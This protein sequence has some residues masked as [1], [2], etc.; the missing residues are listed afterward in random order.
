MS[1]DAVR[2]EKVKVLR[3][4][5]LAAR[6]RD[7][8]RRTRCARSTPPVRSTAAGAGLSRGAGRRARLDDAD[9]RRGALLRRQLALEGVPFYLRS[10]KRLAKRVSEIAVQFRAPPHL[11]FGH[12]TRDADRAERARRCA[13]SRTRACRSTSR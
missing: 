13:C 4:D 2:D 8:F 11:M 9:V 10:G 7:R 5:P 1:A 6:P 12:E 3:V